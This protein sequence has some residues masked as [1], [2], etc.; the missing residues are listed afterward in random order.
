MSSTESQPM[1][2][3]IEVWIAAVL[4]VVAF[5]VGTVTGM[6]VKSSS[7]PEPSPAVTVPGMPPGVVPA[8]PLS[9]DQ[10]SGGLPEG[11]VPIEE[12]TAPQDG[13]KKD[14]DE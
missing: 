8:P 7:E 2:A 9:G 12:G 6:V 3:R 1:K 4:M 5:A 14:K 13:D 11:H 10:L